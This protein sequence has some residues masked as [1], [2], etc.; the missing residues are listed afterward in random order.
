MALQKLL[1]T[2]AQVFAGEHGYLV[3][4]RRQ[5]RIV[6]DSGAM[7]RGKIDL[8]TLTIGLGPHRMRERERPR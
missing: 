1:R 7:S 8:G 3:A 5:R 4:H 6:V 2:A